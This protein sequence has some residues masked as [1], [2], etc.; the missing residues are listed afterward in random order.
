MNLE[1][2]KF[3]RCPKTH[4]EL[5][6][7]SVDLLIEDDKL[8][9]G[10]L[11][12]P[13]SKNKY[14]VINFIPRFVE[15][16]NYANS[17]GLE[18]NKHSKT[19]VDEF[20]GLD[21]SRER[22]FNETKWLDDSTGSKLLEVG[23]GSG[24]FTSHALSTGADVFSIDFS[25]AVEANY[26]NNGHHPNLLI[27]QASVYE[28]PFDRDY[29][30]KVLCIGVLQHTPNPR[31]SFKKLVESLKPGGLLVTDIYLK[32]FSQVYLTPKYLFRIFTKHMNPDVL[33]NY[34]E[35]YITAV[36]PFAKVISKI[37]YLGPRIN[38]RL[39]V[40]DYRQFFKISDD[41]ILKE[42][43][44]LDTFDM[45]SPRYD[46]PETKRNFLK[47]HRE[48]KLENID[49]HYGYNGIE[50]RAQKKS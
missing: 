32:S 18:W 25:N 28:L 7:S 39:L 46:L 6:I 2:I 3:L 21:I 17:F 43:A 10:F 20:S 35:K 48:E 45:L 26:K 34:I 9:H 37:P 1:K 8:K 38:W 31:L 5:E 50:A 12:E 24:R 14:P 36:W 33:Y 30:D 15:M 27:V 4:G 19:Q 13:I 42:M 41:K 47:W 44:I 23:S 11:I 29:F 16:E 22:F 40:A 49:I